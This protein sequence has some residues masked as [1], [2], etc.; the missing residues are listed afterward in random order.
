[1]IPLMVSFD[2]YIGD[3]KIKYKK[4]YFETE[5]FSNEDLRFMNKEI[6]DFPI[7]HVNFNSATGF[8]EANERYTAFHGDLLFDESKLND[9]VANND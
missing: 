6:V 1:M 4:F 5:L 9:H 3:E 2:T 8:F 7:G